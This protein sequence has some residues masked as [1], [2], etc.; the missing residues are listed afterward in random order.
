M[1]GAASA[2]L[3]LPLMSSL[4]ILSCLGALCAAIVQRVSQ[5]RSSPPNFLRRLLSKVAILCKLIPNEV[6]ISS[7][8]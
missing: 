6:S 2:P 7:F 1:P 5:L 4:L 3:S 8:I